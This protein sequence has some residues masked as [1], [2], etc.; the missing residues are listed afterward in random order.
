VAESEYRSGHFAVDVLSFGYLTRE[1]LNHHLALKKKNIIKKSL[2]E[3]DSSLIK[4]Q[5]K[6]LIC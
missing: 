6:K 2:L 1:S 3:N 5:T 4:N